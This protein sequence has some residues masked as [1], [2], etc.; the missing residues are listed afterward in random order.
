[1]KRFLAIALAVLMLVPLCVIGISAEGEG[2][3]EAATCSVGAKNIANEASV[4]YV[5][6]HFWAINGAKLVDNNREELAHSPVYSFSYTFK[7]GSLKTISSIVALVNGTG[8][9]SSCGYE[10]TAEGG[11]TVRGIS[12]KCY[13]DTGKVVY[14]SDVIKLYDDTDPENPIIGTEAKFEFDSLAVSSVEMFVETP[15]WGSAYFREV[16]IYQEI[17]AHAWEVDAENSVA[18]S[19]EESGIDAFKCACGATKEVQTNQHTVEEWTTVLA[20][21]TTSSGIAQGPCTVPGCGGTAAKALPRLSLTDNQKKLNLNHLTVTE[22]VYNIQDYVGESH[23]DYNNNMYMPNPT[24]S[25]LALFDNIIDNDTFKPT[26]FWCG[27]AFSLKKVSVPDDPATPED[28]TQYEIVT[29]DDPATEDVDETVYAYQTYYST[30][31]IEFDQVYSL[32][33][34][35]LYAYSNWNNFKIEFKGANGN[36]IKEITK[37]NFQTSSYE[38]LIFTGDIYGENVKSIVITVMGAKWEGGKGLAFTEFK[39]SAHEC[40]FSDADIASGSTENCVTTFNGTCLLCKAAR[41]DAKIVSHVWEKDE[42]DATQDK[43]VE[44]LTEVT[45]YG[46]GQVLKHCT[47]CDQNVSLVVP[48]TEEHVWGETRF[49]KAN[50]TYAPTCGDVGLGYERCTNEGCTSTSEIHT[51]PPQ[52][53]HNYKWIEKVGFEADYTHDGVKAF[54]CSVCSQIDDSKGTQV[55]PMLDS[56]KL[57]AA[58]DWSVRYTDFVSPRATFKLSMAAINEIELSGFSVKVFGVV[59]KGEETREVQVYGDGARGLIRKDGTFSLVVKDGQYSDDYKFSVRIEI[60]CLSD[61]TSST[62]VA[63]SKNLSTA[64]DGFVSAQ[65]IANYYL[66]PNRVGNLN[67]GVKALYEEIVK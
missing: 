58:K 3:E 23:A 8:H 53:E 29:P 36:V 41:T 65:D 26:N 44:T 1:M 24:K 15:S 43:I 54:T 9:C 49:D 47:E 33:Q 63:A 45:C 32:T 21:T 34:A 67:E 11:N 37:A 6:T 35:E 20:P 7:F 61:S 5:G 42:T 14:E 60:Y 55:S 38:R 13:D 48:A 62:G 50:V 40:E 64:G 28:E 4:G 10:H 19:C 57:A 2:A 16:E 25:A 66:A 56:K 22:N 52:G 30:L 12:I 39:L 51:V 31:T 27:T 59:Q 46:N 18:S 17:G